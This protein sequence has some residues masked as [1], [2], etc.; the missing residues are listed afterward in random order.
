MIFRSFLL[1]NYPTALRTAK[2]SYLAVLSM[3]GLNHVSNVGL[4]VGRWF[5]QI[6]EMADV[7][8]KALIRLLGWMPCN[9]MSFLTVFQSYQ[10]DGWMIMK[11]CVQ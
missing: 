2:T 10:D 11:G 8:L 9:F 7:I 1:F 4:P 6:P 5:E 3:T